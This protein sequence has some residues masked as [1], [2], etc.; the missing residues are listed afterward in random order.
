M[1]VTAINKVLETVSLRSCVILP[2]FKSRLSGRPP[3]RT[4]GAFGP[5]TE[6]Q[7]ERLTPAGPPHVHLGRGPAE[8]R[9]LCAPRL[10]DVEGLAGEGEGAIA[11][12]PHE[13][14]S[15]REPPRTGHGGDFPGDLSPRV[16]S[17][18]AVLL[19]GP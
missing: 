11:S 6:T 18:V 1:E 17:Q 9:H 3:S 19:S 7:A 4:R 5:Q 12:F 10:R 14:A 2:Y 13:R 15:R 8:R 16:Q